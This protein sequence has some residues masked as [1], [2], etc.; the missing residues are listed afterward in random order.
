[1]PA[2][3]RR[4]KITQNTAC[5]WNVFTIDPG[6]GNLEE[7]EVIDDKAHIGRP[8]SQATWRRSL[9]ARRRFEAGLPPGRYKVW[10]DSDS[11]SRSIPMTVPTGDGPL[12]LP[13]IHLESMPWFKM[14]GKPAAEIEAIDLSGKPVQLADFRGKTVILGFWSTTKESDS[15]TLPH[16]ARIQDR[17]NGKPLVIL[18]FHDASIT[19]VS[20]YK[21]AIIPF[22]AQFRGAKGAFPARSAAHS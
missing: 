18:A 2:L 22:R 11:V 12:D 16:L 15:P 9:P 14:L 6:A 4:P 21:E 3:S 8:V 13:G 10:F 20:E 19:S 7:I 5:A 17:F 1:M